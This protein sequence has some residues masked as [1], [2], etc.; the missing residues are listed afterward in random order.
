MAGSSPDT[1]GWMAG[2]GVP[3]GRRSRTPGVV[4][5]AELV[6]F[7]DGE[8]AAVRCGS[9]HPYDLL[10]AADV[11]V[12]PA[13]RTT[14]SAHSARLERARARTCTR[15]H[16]RARTQGSTVAHRDT[17]ARTVHISASPHAHTR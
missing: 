9:R 8:A 10:V 6:A 14:A 3:R 16:T 17:A 7:L 1:A 4:Q 12:A 2:R 13:Q 5:V 15:T 11:W